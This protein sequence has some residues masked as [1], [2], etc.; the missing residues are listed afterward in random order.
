MNLFA[1]FEVDWG[2]GT[3]EEFKL[4]VAVS[5]QFDYVLNRLEAQ[6]T[7]WELE[8]FVN[9]KSSYSK[10]A[11]RLLKQWRTVGKKSYKLDEFRE[12]FDVPKS[13][14]NT[15]LEQKVLKPIREEL[16]AFFKD[17][18]IQKVYAKKRGKPLVGFIF[19][20]KPEKTGKYDPYKYEKTKKHTIRKETL[21]DWAKSPEKPKDEVM[22]SENEIQ[23]YEDWMSEIFGQKSIE[24][25]QKK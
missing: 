12:L 21:P 10:V 3:G 1:L 22:M 16:P 6:F 17:F 20:W 9:I 13:Y 18:H 15:H 4:T 14:K 2:K 25:G 7:I 5:N 11:F 19:S 8:E 24:W 23:E